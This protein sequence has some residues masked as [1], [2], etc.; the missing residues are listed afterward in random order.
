MPDQTT[1]SISDVL[2]AIDALGARLERV[3]VEQKATIG[4][5][6]KVE[7]DVAACRAALD[8]HGKH[9][10]DIQAT[11]RA[12][13][14]KTG[15]VAATLEALNARVDVMDKRV[16]GAITDLRHVAERIDRVGIPAE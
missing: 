2:D 13:Q 6:R 15:D 4:H 10:T 12:V 7:D 9:L 8:V 1:P 16:A 14:T 11:A 3:E 5:I